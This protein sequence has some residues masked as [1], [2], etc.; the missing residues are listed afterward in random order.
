K[1]TDFFR[2][3]DLFEH[4]RSTL[5]PKL[6]DDAQERRE[7]RIWSAGCATGEEAYSLA[8]LVAEA[9]GP[10]LGRWNIRIF[11]T[12]ADPEA[13]AFA[14]RGVYPASAVRGVDARTLD[15]HF[16]RVDSEF[17]VGGHVRAMTVFGEHD[18]AQRAPFPRIDLIMCRN[19]LIYFTPDLQRRALQL[20]A[21][22]LRDGGFLAL[23]KSETTSPQPSSFVPE[24]PGLRIFRRS[25]ERTG[26][27]S[28]TFRDTPQPDVVHRGRGRRLAGP[29]PIHSTDDG[30]RITP[31]E[32]AETILLRVPIGV[33]V[34]DKAYTTVFLNTAARTLLG[35]HGA[36]I[37]Q[38]FVH[39]ARALDSGPLRE[40]LDRAVGGDSAELRAAVTSETPVGHPRVLKLTFAPMSFDSAGGDGHVLVTVLD[41]TSGEMKQTEQEAEVDRLSAE[42]SRLRG[43]AERLGDTNRDLLRGND[44]LAVS[45]AELRTVN[46]ELVVYNEELQAATEEVETLNEELQAT[47]EEL[48][49]LNEELQ[50]TVEELNTANDDLAAR[51]ALDRAAEAAPLRVLPPVEH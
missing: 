41:V 11:A 40:G 44:E 20:F 39:Q 30:A 43:Q 38:D 47:N 32:R 3:P 6:I 19:V 21:F 27:P 37:G 31:T 16:R 49:T 15:R 23:G 29:G 22:S 12:D 17:E 25:G 48:E 10:E 18:L 26:V 4:V 14:R 51:A 45:N 28:T 46:E 8:I 24:Q 13:I 9:L 36:A 7:L 35:I 2:D 34:V 42:L 1:V 33:C 5:L 50:A